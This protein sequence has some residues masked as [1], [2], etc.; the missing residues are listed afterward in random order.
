MHWRV[1]NSSIFTLSY[2]SVPFLCAQWHWRKIFSR[3]N[4]VSYA[5]SSSKVVIIISHRLEINQAKLGGDFHLVKLDWDVPLPFLWLW[6]ITKSDSKTVCQLWA[7]CNAINSI[8]D[9]SDVDGLQRVPRTHLRTETHFA[10][11]AIPVIEFQVQG[12]MGRFIYILDSSNTSS[13]TFRT[14]FQL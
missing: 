13:I 8:Q 1:K 10:F 3:Q 5:G 9:Y 4:G 11:I 2:V 7:F 12:Y 14:R 6:E